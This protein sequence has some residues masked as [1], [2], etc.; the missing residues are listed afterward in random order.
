MATVYYSEA[1]RKWGVNWRD[2]GKRHRVLVG[3][4]TAA[5]AE[6][7]RVKRHLALGELVHPPPVAPLGEYF[8]F[9]IDWTQRHKSRRTAQHYAKVVTDFRYFCAA[10]HFGMLGDIKPRHIEEFKA[11]RAA[12]VSDK[13]VANE[14]AVLSVFFRTAVKMEYLDRNPMDSVERVRPVAKT[15]RYLTRKEAAALLAA[16]PDYERA[17]WTVLL[18][19]GMRRGEVENLE[20]EDVDLRRKVLT[21][22][23]RRDW[24]PKGKRSRGVPMHPEVKA[25]LKGLPRRSDRLVFATRNGT[26]LK[27]LDRKFKRCVE[28]AGL[29]DVTIHTLRHTCASHLVMAGVDL[30]TVAKILGHRDITTTMRYAHLA[31]EHI[32]KAVERLIL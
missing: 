4:K 8:S 24:L 30:P 10:R 31:T 18:Y 23:V 9:F 2:N 7:K 22:R 3:S 27:H 6:L 17:I 28:K 5:Q 25:A 16:S 15:P 1:R 13:T 14:L 11:A 20:W 26:P 19:T 32:Q 21:L 29:R 12:V